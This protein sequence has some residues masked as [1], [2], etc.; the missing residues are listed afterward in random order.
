[1]CC[2]NMSQCVLT[3]CYYNALTAY[4]TM[5]RY[6]ISSD[7][8]LSQN[9]KRLIGV[10]TLAIFG[11]LA[12]LLTA[13]LS[14]EMH[15]PWRWL[16]GLLLLQTLLVVVSSWRVRQPWQV[17]PAEFM[18][19]ICLDVLLLLGVFA[20]TGGAANPFVYV[21]LLPLL[22]A[23]A[24]LSKPQVLGVAVLVVAG[25][26]LLLAGYQSADSQGRSHHA[27]SS[28]FDWHV[29]GMWFG[30]VFCVVIVVVF[31]MR[32]ADALRQ[33]DQILAQAREQA[34]RD[35]QLIALGTLAAGAAHELGTPLSTMAVL[36][37]ELQQEYEGD[38]ELAESLSLLDQQVRRCKHSLSQISVASGQ[39][40][41]ESGNRLTLDSFLD[42]IVQDWLQRWPKASLE[43]R[44]DGEQP[45]PVVVA[46][47]GLS[48]ALV[49]FLDNAAQGSPQAVS[50]H[51]RWQS[52]Q[53]TIVI[54]DRGP[55]V[56]EA[57]RQQLGKLPVTTRL[58]GGGLGVMLAYAVIQRLGGEVTLLPREGGGT[59]VDIVLPLDKLKVDE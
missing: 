49:N 17:S 12:A 13:S 26:S 32:M 1:M 30:F 7:M 47:Q 10:R 58:D 14:L 34:L 40:R 5:N 59:R 43:Y 21:L 20:A 55:G 39:L 42:G 11:E 44:A 27:P 54:Q 19:H 2:D 31:V 28:A 22:M 16:A 52:R 3:D 48:Q 25:Y 33:R 24:Q 8:I 46:E 6:S 36:C 51:C 38:D 4:D 23:A 9:L 18:L 41:A 56:S 15:F 29:F 57:V 53:L 37:Q 50:L 35:E 45:V